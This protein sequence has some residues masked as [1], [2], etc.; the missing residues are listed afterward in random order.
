MDNSPSILHKYSHVWRCRLIFRRYFFFVVLRPSEVTSSEDLFS[1]VF[2]PTLEPVFVCCVLVADVF[3]EVFVV[4]VL[5]VTFAELLVVV[6]VVVLVTGCF[7]TGAF[8]VDT[9]DVSNTAERQNAKNENK[10][11]RVIVVVFFV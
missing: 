2:T 3:V 9:H 7:F 6:L 1:V 4:D 10:A 11:L 5:F 8:A